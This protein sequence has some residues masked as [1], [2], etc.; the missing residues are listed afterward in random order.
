[1]IATL[2]LILHIAPAEVRDMEI[3]DRAAILRVLRRQQEQAK[4]RRR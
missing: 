4:R 3:R 2:A 1:M